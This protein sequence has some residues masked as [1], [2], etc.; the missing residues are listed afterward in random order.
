MACPLSAAAVT[1]TVTD[2]DCTRLTA[3]VP[4]PGV[5]YRPGV[6]A[7]GEAVIPA[8]LGGGLRI[9]APKEIEIPIQID[10]QRKIGVPVNPDQFQT[11]DTTVGT[12]TWRDGRV[13]Y[14][15][16]PL[17]D[18]ETARIARLCQTRGSGGAA[19]EKKGKS[20]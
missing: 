17:L 12:V 19:K 15:G 2:D 4:D 8:D 6:D 18:E 11:K 7:D 13:F 20:E 3:H 14:N 10:L 1:V 5:A 16:Q 9:E